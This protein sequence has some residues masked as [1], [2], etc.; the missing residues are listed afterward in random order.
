[1]SYEKIRKGNPTLIRANFKESEF[2]PNSNGAMD[3]IDFPDDLYFHGALLN[4]A[5]YLRNNFGVCSVNSTAR[6]ERTNRASGGEKNSKHL[7]VELEPNKLGSH[8]FDLGFP[9]EKMALIRELV[10]SGSLENELRRMGIGG[11]GLYNTFIHIDT[12]AVRNWDKSTDTGKKK[13]DEENEGN[14]NEKKRYV[15][16]FVVVFIIFVIYKFFTK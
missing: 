6:T 11:I 15:T 13:D 16:E 10:R 2:H 3:D 5:Q 8:A 4:A 9:S 14:E 12:G 7:L 1:M